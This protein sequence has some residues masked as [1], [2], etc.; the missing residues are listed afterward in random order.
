[1]GC[2][3]V[4]VSLACGQVPPPSA[5]N[6]V[7][8]YGRLDQRE[9]SLPGDQFGRWSCGPTSLVNSLVYLENRFAYGRSLIPDVI[10]GYNPADYLNPPPVYLP[11]NGVMD[12]VEMVAVGRVLASP[13]Y[14][15]QKLGGAAAAVNDPYRHSPSNPP[16][17][18]FPPYDD[19]SGGPAG[20]VGGGVTWQRFA[21]GKDCWFTRPG[22]PLG[23]VLRGQYTGPW[24]PDPNAPYD[25][26]NPKDERNFPQPVWLDTGVNLDMTEMF[27]W[28]SVG[29]DVEI[30]WIWTGGA[31][32]HFSTVY[33]YD[34][35]LD[36]GMQG[37]FDPGDLGILYC[38]DPWGAGAGGLADLV[39]IPIANNAGSIDLSPYLAGAS[40]GTVGGRMTI[41]TSELPAPG[42]ASL[43][44]R[45]G[46][47]AARRRR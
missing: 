27:R 44:A 5:I 24:V 33:G 31:G 7:A 9:L 39:S 42:G 6:N 32:G 25:P 19:W 23:S 40:N 45:G 28:L 17:S 30:G 26:N 43:L 13:Q 34:W 41:W 29:A 4:P 37:V 11:N 2:V 8:L 22:V 36:Q 15:N 1:V 35:I 47:I 12:T 46:M 38:I 10:P 14:M 18:T 16:P 3:F 20:S 21:Y